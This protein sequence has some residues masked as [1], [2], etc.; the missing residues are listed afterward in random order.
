MSGLKC[1]LSTGSV[2]LN[3]IKWETKVGDDI[4]IFYTKS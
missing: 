3:E 2:Q 1:I 4:R